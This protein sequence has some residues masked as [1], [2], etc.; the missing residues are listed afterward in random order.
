LLCS[1]ICG[2]CKADS[3]EDD[4]GART[5]NIPCSTSPLLPPLLPLL[6][7]L[8]ASGEDAALML[9]MT[10]KL[11]TLRTLSMAVFVAVVEP[12]CRRSGGCS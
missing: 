4:V 12:L 7:L 5:A 1:L 11:A 8:L 2:G 6:P 3:E 9:L 10:F